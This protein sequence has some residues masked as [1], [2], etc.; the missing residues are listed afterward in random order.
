M[1]T[2]NILVLAILSLSITS[3]IQ[4]YLGHGDDENDTGFLTETNY[5][6]ADDL[7]VA[8][9][10]NNL[11]SLKEEKEEL[12]KIIEGGDANDEQTQRLKA[13]NNEIDDTNKSIDI[14]LDYRADV[15]LIVGPKPPCPRPRLC[16]LWLDMIYVT[17]GPRFVSYQIDVYGANEEIIGQTVGDPKELLGVD[18]LINYVDFIWSNKDYKG[19]IL[20]KAY[21]VT[22]D[23]DEEFSNIYSNIN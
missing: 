9:L 17:P 1:K 6:Y 5:L 14:T 10:E 3:C 13:V 8:F 20:L 22:A 18:G 21:G 12:D 4:D 11:E 15:F 7:K 2:K 19:E 23:G 16:D